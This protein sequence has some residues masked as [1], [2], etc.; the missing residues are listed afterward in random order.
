MIP[1]GATFLIFG[2]YMP[3]PMRLAALMKLR[4]RYILTH[5]SIGLGEDGP[6]H[7]PVEQLSTMRA[8]PGFATFRPGDANETRECWKA[9]L[10]WE[11]PAALVL[12]RQDIPTMDRDVSGTQR[13]P[14]PRK[15][16]RHLNLTGGR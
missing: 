11:G 12:T 3:P 14:M 9:A 2:D 15:P 6:T 4:T 1:S 13:G 7:Q 8:I 5:D 16:S 10:Q